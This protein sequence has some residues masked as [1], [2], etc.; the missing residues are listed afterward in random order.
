M[1]IDNTAET[2]QVADVGQLPA[3]CNTWP[4]PSSD[5]DLVTPEQ[6][7]ATHRARGCCKGGSDGE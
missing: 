5:L 4:W 3:F 7:M 1:Q 2:P 6:N